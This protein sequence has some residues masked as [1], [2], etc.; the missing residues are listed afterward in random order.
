MEYI[1]RDTSV[2]TGKN[3]LEPLY[4]FKDFPV[5]MGCTN[6][7]DQG[8]DIKADMSF[9][10]C[11]D[12]GIIQLDKL[13]PLE[14]V[15][16][17]QHNDGVGKVWLDHYR[18]F[19]QF[20]EKFQPRH[21]LEIGGASDVI[22][23]DFLSR[24]KEVDWTV[25]EP[26]PLFKEGN[27]VRIIEKWFDESF[28]FDRPV[29]TIVHSHVL[30]HT[31]TPVSFIR[32]IS[33]FLKNGDRHVF[34]FP[35]MIEMLSKKYTNCLNF[36]HTAFLTEPF[37]DALLVQNGFRI[38]EKEYYQD[39]SIFYATE[40]VEKPNGE[41]FEFPNKYQEYKKLFQDFIQYHERLVA[42]LNQEIQQHDGDVYLFGAHIFSQYLLE[43]GLEQGA[44]RCIL[45]NSE[46]KN[47]KRLY[48]TGLIVESPQ[49]IK[50]SS[51]PC[52][53]LKIGAYR[54]EVVRQLEGLHPGV[55][56]LE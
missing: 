28:T 26:H 31:Y 41:D 56:I 34:T 53:I 9:A 2:L 45:D 30:E 8:A 25:V 43:F 24:N 29:D 11:R 39:H 7:M 21:I 17:S 1:V 27:G 32:H 38:I 50:G 49:I 3:N 22:A 13:L 42:R 51:R 44:I 35:N 20:L 40:R 10:I 6:E 36:E 4:M 23:R 14:L 33:S 55:K 16:Q 5:F 48:G 47:K 19:A 15:Y 46:I 18:A 37:V 52:V 54:N 12:T